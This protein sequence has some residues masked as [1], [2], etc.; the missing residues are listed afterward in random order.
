MLKTQREPV[1]LIEFYVERH[2]KKYVKLIVTGRYELFGPEKLYD[3]IK[4]HPGQ[5]FRIT[6]RV[7]TDP[8]LMP[9]AAIEQ[10]IS[11]MWNLQI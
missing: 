9:E 10:F 5:K 2:G 8:Q 3:L 1:M 4:R 11:K 6:R 7:F